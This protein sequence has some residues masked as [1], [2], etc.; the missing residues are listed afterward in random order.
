MMHSH[1]SATAVQHICVIIPVYNRPNVLLR[2]LNAILQQDTLP[3]RLVICNDGSSDTTIQ[4]ARD[5]VKEHAPPFKVDLLDLPHKGAAAA[6]N[7]GLENA[8]QQKDCDL[9]H[10]L[11][12][13]DIP[14]V[15]FLKRCSTY[16]R[17]H[18][19]VVGVCAARLMRF[20]EEDVFDSFRSFVAAPIAWIIK[21]GAGLLSCSVLRLDAVRA[22]GGFD[23]SLP[24][25]HDMFFFDRL[26]DQGPMHAL[27]GAAVLSNRAR[28]ETMDH[29]NLSDYIPDR[30]AIGARIREAIIKRRGESS[31]PYARVLHGLWYQACKRAQHQ[32]AAGPAFRFCL[33]A[34]R[35]RPSAWRPYLRLVLICGLAPF[36]FVRRR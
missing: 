8:L 2:S 10:F 9:V 20:D 18:P 7:A 14:P 26:L 31:R 32:R 24:T 6:R 22:I 35:W 3:H 12:S 19:Q 11:D 1:S 30:F 36:F 34:I 28:S 13:D 4:V 15:D 27:S 23:E 5:W 29:G 16:L 25:G 33:K 17:A 21:Y